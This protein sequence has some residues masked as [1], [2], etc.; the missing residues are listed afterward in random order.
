VSK[1]QSK[2]SRATEGF[3]INFKIINYFGNKTDQVLGRLSVYLPNYS[4]AKAIHILKPTPLLKHTN[5]LF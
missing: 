4:V 2:N 1:D 5:I 3:F